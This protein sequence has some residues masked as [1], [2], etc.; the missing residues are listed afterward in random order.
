MDGGQDLGSVAGDGRLIFGLDAVEEAL[1][2]FLFFFDCFA[3]AA[4]GAVGDADDSGEVFP[5]GAG[6][7]GFAE[8]LEVFFVHGL[9]GPSDCS[10][11]HAVATY[12]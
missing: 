3:P 2:V 6:L 8:G 10:G 12:C 5:G 1:G 4:E 7:G 9:G 11:S